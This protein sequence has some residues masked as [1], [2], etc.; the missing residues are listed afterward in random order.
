MDEKDVKEMVYK[1][2]TEKVMYDCYVM[3]GIW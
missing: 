2:L 3:C 1:E